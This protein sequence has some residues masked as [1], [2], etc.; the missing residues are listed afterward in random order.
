MGSMHI[1]K[2]EAQNKIW[3]P[4]FIEWRTEISVIMINPTRINGTKIR[5][6]ASRKDLQLYWKCGVD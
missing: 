5:F 1:K 2:K 3:S 6:E 4:S